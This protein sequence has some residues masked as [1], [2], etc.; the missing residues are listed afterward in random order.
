MQPKRVDY[1]IALDDD[2]IRTACEDHLRR[3][4]STA[5]GAAESSISINHVIDG[6]A[7]LRYRPVAVS[8]ETKTPEGGELHGRTQLSIWGAGHIMRLRSAR[9]DGSDD[10]VALPLVLVVGT[11]W[12]AYFLVDR[13]ECLVS[14]SPIAQRLLALPHWVLR[15]IPS[16]QHMFEAG[17]PEDT[18]SVVGC[19]RVVAMIRELALWSINVYRPW[20]A[21]AV[22]G[23][24]AD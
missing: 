11:R 1:V 6:A 12:M 20:F 7:F 17:P 9:R 23:I 14:L 5:G 19:Y 16:T 15:L 3:Q 8:I 10:E 13:G 4:V 24:E 21:K 2:S 18:L 22:L